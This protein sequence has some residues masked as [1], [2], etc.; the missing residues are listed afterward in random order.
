MEQPC[1]L[2]KRAYKA[3]HSLLRILALQFRDLE[4]DDHEGGDYEASKKRKDLYRGE[5]SSGSG[6]AGG[7]E[8]TE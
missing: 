6:G 3:S 8:V 1:H 2:R 5:N 4:P 7:L